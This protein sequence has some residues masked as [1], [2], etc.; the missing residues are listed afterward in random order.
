M[1]LVRGLEISFKTGK[2]LSNASSFVKAEEKASLFW[3]YQLL[4]NLNKRE[5]GC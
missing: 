5:D 4:N 3:L 1:D 2:I